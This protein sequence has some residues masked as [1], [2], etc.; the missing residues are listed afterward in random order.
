MLIFKQLYHLF[1]I[2]TVAIC[3][4]MTVNFR[5][6]HSCGAVRMPVSGYSAEERGT[7][8]TDSYKVFVKDSQGQ[9]YKKRTFY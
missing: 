4:I 3:N 1:I 7:S 9:L 6:V 2:F 5:L 8:N